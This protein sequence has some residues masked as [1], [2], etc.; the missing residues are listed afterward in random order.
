MNVSL[1]TPRAS[2]S[3]FIKGNL[4]AVVIDLALN[5]VPVFN[6]SSNPDIDAKNSAIDFDAQDVISQLTKIQKFKFSGGTQSVS[7][8][9][10]DGAGGSGTVKGLYN[11]PSYSFGDGLV[12][13]GSNIISAVSALQQ[14]RTDIYAAP[15]ASKS[16]DGG[17]PPVGTIPNRLKEV[18]KTII[19]NF[20]EYMNSNATTGLDREIILT[21]H[22]QNQKAIQIWYNILDYSNEDNYYL[23]TDTYLALDEAITD[24]ITRIYLSNSNNFFNAVLQF[25]SDFKMV[26]IPPSSDPSNG[27]YGKLKGIS[28]IFASPLSKRINLVMFNA[29]IRG[30]N[31]P[32]INSVWVTGDGNMGMKLGGESSTQIFATWPTTDK[33]EYTGRVY[34]VPP[35]PWVPQP[36]PLNFQVETVPK[37]LRSKQAVTI[38][39]ISNKNLS[40]IQKLHFNIFTEWARLWFIDVLYSNEIASIELPLDLSWQPGMYCNVSSGGGK[41]FKGLVNSVRHELTV[42]NAR[43]TIDF[44]H[45]VY[46]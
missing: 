45:V 24:H 43:T 19:K 4:D 6:I 40:D 44:S 37:T 1:R 22:K 26:Y 42:K 31:T 27:P 3:S 41:L 17:S 36:S 39:N 38:I 18:L 33:T 5:T 35:P 23:L 15:T 34:K 2:A 21:Q 16:G 8:S 11:G 14:L 20:E 32:A 10:S 25:C 29:D 7:V 12:S 9:V 46:S 13:F 30:F 28:N